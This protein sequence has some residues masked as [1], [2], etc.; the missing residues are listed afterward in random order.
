M[1]VKAHHPIVRAE[2]TKYIAL[3]KIV[4]YLCQTQK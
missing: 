2:W 3:C 1:L 4:E